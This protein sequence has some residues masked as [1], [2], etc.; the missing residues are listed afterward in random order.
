MSETIIPLVLFALIS[1]S[2]PGIAT[3]LSTASGAQFGFRRSVPL[4][5]GSA[6]GLAS[7][8]AA[9]AAGL[10]GLLAAVPSLQLAMKIAGSLYLIWLAVKI[11]RSGPPNLDVT[12]AKPNS[13]FGGAG[14]QWM[15]PKGWAMG[16]G[17]AASFATLADGPLQL[18]LLLSAVFGLAAAF[19]LSL[20]CTAGTLLARLLRTER[21]WRAL[22]IALGLL[23]AASILQMWRPA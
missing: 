11:G 4:M 16:L 23:L 14:I 12:M 8:A 6:A 2:T 22:N 17:A 9:G 5:A 3:T 13:F 10:A 20:W 19:S 7:V 18:A 1:T 15:N 21:Q